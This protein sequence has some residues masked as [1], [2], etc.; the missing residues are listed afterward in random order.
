MYYRIAMLAVVLIALI[1][2]SHRAPDDPDQVVDAQF[3]VSVT[4]L[5]DTCNDMPFYK[6]T[7]DVP[8]PVVD[9][10]P[11]ANGTLTGTITPEE[12]NVDLVVQREHANKKCVRRVNLF[13]HARPLLDPQA[14]DGLYEI[15]VSNYGIRCPHDA[16]PPRL[17]EQYTTVFSVDQ[18]TYGAFVF[19]PTSR[20]WPS[21]LIAFGPFTLDKDGRMSWTGT[22]DRGAFYGTVNG[23]VRPGAVDLE[24]EYNLHD[25]TSGCPQR[26]TLRGAKR[27]YSPASIDNTYRVDIKVNDYGC[28][29]GYFVGAGGAVDII[30]QPNGEVWLTDQRTTRILKPNG[31]SEYIEYRGS[32]LEGS[33]SRV[34]M[35]ATPPHISY[36]VERKYLFNREWCT[37]SYT[38]TGVARFIP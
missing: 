26:F 31:S 34:I 33:M 27:T 4:W 22:L 29:F 1:G 37:T 16:T 25:D 15:T 2:C 17:Q 23:V 3:R 14:L 11:R 19:S 9:V 20:D 5:E 12:M 10:L 8:G 36:F 6:L 18:N 38:G 30:T 7:P 32:L 21:W 35:T 24:L 28:D 13:G